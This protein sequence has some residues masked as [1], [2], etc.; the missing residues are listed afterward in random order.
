MSLE[1]RWKRTGIEAVHRCQSRTAGHR[2]DPLSCAF[3]QKLPTAVRKTRSGKLP[4]EM[5]QCLATIAA[6]LQDRKP[7]MP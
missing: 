6:N 7:A 3:V 4:A 1:G 5:A 2:Q